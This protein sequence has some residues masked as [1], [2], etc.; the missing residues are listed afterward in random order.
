MTFAQAVRA[1][2]IFDELEKVAEKFWADLDEI[3]LSP[4]TYLGPAGPQT[5]T[6][7]D[8]DFLE[9]SSFSLALLLIPSF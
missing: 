6:I 7:R 5:H 3:I 9:V 8:F 2:E 1:L 4:R